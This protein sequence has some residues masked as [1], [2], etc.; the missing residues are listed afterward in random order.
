MTTAEMQMVREMFA[1]LR[2]HGIVARMALECCSS[3]AWASLENDTLVPT[4]CVFFHRQ[5]DAHA[6]SA[7]DAT[8]AI[9]YGY[10]HNELLGDSSDA[11][12]TE[13]GQIV[14]KAAA[15]GGLYYEWNGRPSQ[16]VV[17]KHRE[18]T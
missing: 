12:L 7:P 2:K 1:T 4:P 8:L 3:C 13:L 9:A 15:G 17:L 14:A 18:L 11:L 5:D 16:R 10:T 6:R